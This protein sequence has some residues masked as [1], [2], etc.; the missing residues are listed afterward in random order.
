MRAL[1]TRGWA[2]GRERGEGGIGPSPRTEPPAA[3]GHTPAAE[4]PRRV[5]LAHPALQTIE[6]CLCEVEGS[7]TT[8][9]SRSG[10][11]RRGPRPPALVRRPARPLGHPSRNHGSTDLEAQRARRRRGKRRGERG[12]G[13]VCIGAHPP[14]ARHRPQHL[15]CCAKRSL[16]RS[17][18]PHS[19]RTRE[20]AARWARAAPTGSRPRAPASAPS[21]PLRCCW[22]RRRLHTREGTCS[23]C[24]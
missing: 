9:G 11:R 17:S 3:P 13:A 21:R 19:C 22:E 12:S 23:I 16:P 7:L 5:N 10:L 1:L 20:R 6:L 14:R 8:L 4:R 18:R 15:G 2:D 24:T